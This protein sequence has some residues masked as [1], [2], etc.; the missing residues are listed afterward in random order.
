[1]APK[2]GPAGTAKSHGD[3]V[4]ARGD[5]LL[6]V[7]VHPDDDVL[8]AGG[9]LQRAV[10]A[11][12]TVHAVFVTDGENNPWAQRAS[13]RRL[14]VLAPDRA[15]FGARRRSEALAALVRLSVPAQHVAFLGLPDQG[16]TP[17]LLAD[18]VRVVAILRD[19]VAHG[20]P[21]LLLGPSAADLHPD[22]SSLA[23]LL[24]LAVAGLP[25]GRRPRELAYVV[26]NPALRRAASP[27]ISLELSEAERTAKLDAILCHSTQLHLR[28]PWLRSFAARAESF[29]VVPT[30]APHPHA[31]ARFTPARALVVPV[32]TQPRARSFGAR[33]LLVMAG[34]G[35]DQPRSLACLLPSFPRRVT[36]RDAASGTR[37]GSTRFSGHAL[38]GTISLPENL[39]A[40]AS[41]V[42]LKL[43]RRFGF[44][45]EAGWL[46]VAKEPK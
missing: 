36:V 34:H 11:G 32:A 21:T 35:D 2:P 18:A 14:V 15:R 27:Q 40:G 19:L 44:F 20:R 23:V 22:H 7:A 46:E 41:R 3:V 38:A 13:E 26:H 12:S 33:T 37:L 42:F 45:D 30:P 43:E 6:V 16:L 29:H 31:G 17:L 8:A 28:G 39:L 25:A 5:R 10:A 24:R 1:M 9:L 4:L